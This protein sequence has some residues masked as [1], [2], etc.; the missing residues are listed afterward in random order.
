MRAALPS[1]GICGGG[2]FWVSM[3]TG[4]APA[5]GCVLV[6][7]SPPQQRPSAPN[8]TASL[9]K[10]I[11]LTLKFAWNIK[12]ITLTRTKNN[13]M[14]IYFKGKTSSRESSEAQLSTCSERRPNVT[15]PNCLLFTPSSRGPES[16]APLSAAPRPSSGGLCPK[17][18]QA[19]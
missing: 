10:T 7:H 3:T 15:V 5:A 4:R 12:I 19:S 2:H 14:E 16:P 11:K 8:A 1:R 17:V 18:S 9:R 13:S 6:C